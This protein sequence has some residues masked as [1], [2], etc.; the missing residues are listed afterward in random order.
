MASP[1][2]TDREYV[3]FKIMGDSGAHIEITDLLKLEP[4]NAWNKGDIN[5]K[6]NKPRKFTSW[7]LES[8]LN[9]THPIQEHLDALFK[10]LVPLQCELLN[11][12]KKFD[13][14]FQCVGYFHPS[15]HGIHLD[16]STVQKASAFAAS[17]DMDF[18]YISDNGHDL[19]YV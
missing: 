14:C 1:P 10:I 8:G 17:F 16:K 12:S 19:D 15:G 2:I 5:I 11:L 7:Q 3:Y 18:Y 9:D 13:I 4:T 6:N